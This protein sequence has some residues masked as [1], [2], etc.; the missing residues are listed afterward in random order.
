MILGVKYLLSRMLAKS[1]FIR[2]VIVLG[3]GTVGAQSI[4]I[5]ASPVLTRLYSPEDFGLIAVFASLLA[6]TLTIASMRYELAIPLPDNDQ[7]AAYIVVLSLVILLVFVGLTTLIIWVFGDQIARLMNIPLL[8]TYLWFLPLGILL[9][10]IYNVF[11]YW[12]IRVKSFP[13]LARTKIIQAFSSVCVQISGVALGQI[14]LLL[15]QVVGQASG[16]TTLSVMAVRKNWDLFRETKFI[17]MAGVA[18]RYR[19]FPLFS[20]CSGIFNTLGL[21]FPTLLF[22]TFFGTSAA[23]V[24]ALANRVLTLPMSLIGTAVANVFFSSAAKASRT[25]RLAPLVARVQENLSQIAMPP[26]LLL[27][28][29]APKIFELI[30]GL[31]WREAGSFARLMAPWLYCV[32]IASPLST[33][34]SVLEMQV[35]GLAFEI[36]LL[37]VR[38]GALVLGA[39]MG[40][41][42]LAI[43]LYA[44]GSFACWLWLL[45]WIMKVSGNRLSI[46]AKSTVRCLVWACILISPQILAEILYAKGFIWIVALISTLFLIMTRYVVLAMK[47]LI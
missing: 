4:L 10:G 19:R 14:S 41:I 44:L 8:S 43:A 31:E 40:N 18:Y 30:F 5:L 15:G 26:T 34:F 16:V 38:T 27:I 47:P 22:V 7:E 29:V 25:G 24:Y 2:H 39:R 42:M 6:I 23:G 13:A 32:F 37:S 21:Y 11:S 46:L 3:G 35:H 1:T 28:V 9:T 17:N 12:A 45:I 20:M 33:L 36:V